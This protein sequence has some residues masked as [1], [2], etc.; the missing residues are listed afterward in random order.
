[1]PK[2]Y[3][4]PSTLFDS[5]QYGFSQIVTTREGMTV[6]LSGQVG[7]DAQQQIVGKDD[8]GKQTQWALH[9]IET[10]PSQQTCKTLH[11]TLPAPSLWILLLGHTCQ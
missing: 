8:L 5:Q 11:H 9:N 4:N 7:W 10:A 1:M 3:A 6:Y 2:A